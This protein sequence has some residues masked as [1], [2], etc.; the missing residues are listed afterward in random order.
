M[1]DLKIR[2]VFEQREPRP[3]ELALAFGYHVT[4]GADRRARRAA[5]L[6][7]DGFVPRLLFTGGAPREPGAEAESVRMARVA[8]EMGVSQESILVEPFSRTT[9]ENVI[10]SRELLR[11]GGLLDATKTILLV[12][13]PWH[14]GRIVRLMKTHFPAGIEHVCCPQTEDCTQERW[15]EC[16]ECRR[17][18]LAEAEFLDDLIR[19]GALPAEIGVRS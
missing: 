14:L 2:R 19:A 9:A 15:Q 4:E 5:Q 12:S 10:R 16:A 3:G 18:V 7:L 13:C 8:R 1:N 11:Q 6:Y 17:R